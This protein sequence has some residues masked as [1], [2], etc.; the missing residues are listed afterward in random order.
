[1]KITNARLYRQIQP[2]ADGPYVCRGQSEDGFDSA[3]VTA[4]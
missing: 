1:M 4:E 3:I 2:F